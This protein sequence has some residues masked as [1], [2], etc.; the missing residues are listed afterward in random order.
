MNTYIIAS[1]QR[2]ENVYVPLKESFSFLV[3][4]WVYVT[5]RSKEPYFISTLNGSV[6]NHT[7]EE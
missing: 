5:L 3:T 4:A 2:R 7:V 6:E 1:L